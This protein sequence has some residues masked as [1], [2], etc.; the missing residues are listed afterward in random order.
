MILEDQII[1]ACRA[2]HY[3][4]TELKSR[5]ANFVGHHYEKCLDNL[6]YEANNFILMT[7]K[8]KEAK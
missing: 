8:N 7:E 2:I 5:E 6:Q 4:V 3:A 1:A